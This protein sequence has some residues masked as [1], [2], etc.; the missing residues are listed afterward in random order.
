MRSTSGGYTLAA[1][2]NASAHAATA[3]QTATWSGPDASLDRGA[4]RAKGERNERRADVRRHRE[5]R[6]REERDHDHHP[7]VQ[8]SVRRRARIPPARPAF[9]YR[10][11]E[12]DQGPRQ[13]AGEEHEREVPGTMR[14]PELL[15]AGVA[16]EMVAYEEEREESG[17]APLDGPEP[18]R[19]Q[20]QDRDDR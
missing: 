8:P 16:H 11:R 5:P 9:G 17:L 7:H 13:R 3:S 15:G 12:S 19:R 14:V 6:E 20:H 1:S 4:R 2:A 10:G 18:C